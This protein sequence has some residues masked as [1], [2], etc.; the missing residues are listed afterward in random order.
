M[1]IIYEGAAE[2]TYTYGSYLLPESQKRQSLLPKG[3]ACDK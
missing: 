1:L 3:S 2:R